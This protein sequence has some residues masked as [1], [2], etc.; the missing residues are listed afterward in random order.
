MGWYGWI[1]FFDELLLFLNYSET[2]FLS[3]I[4]LRFFFDLWLELVRNL[5][6]WFLVWDDT[7][8]PDTTCWRLLASSCCLVLV[9]S[10]SCFL[11]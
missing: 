8:A 7:R 4:L 2:A 10:F 6:L 5:I 3:H 11:D 1:L 9:S